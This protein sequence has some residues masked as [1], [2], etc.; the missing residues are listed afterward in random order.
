MTANEIREKF[1]N[2]FAGAN[3]RIVKSSSLLPKDDPTLLFTN[4]GMVQFKR[5]FLGEEKRDYARATTSQKCVRAGGKHNDLENVGHTAR[6]HT[7]FEML[8]NFSFG[9]Y[10]KREAI[11]FSW[12]LLTEGYGLPKDLLYV[13]VFRDDDEAYDIWKKDIGH[14]EQR[15]IRMGE[16]D[17]FWA[18]G[19][20]GPCGPCSEILIDQ[21]PDMGCDRPDCAP[22]CECD[23]YLELW[24]LVFMQYNRDESGTMTPLPKPSIDTG[25]GLERISAVLQGKKNNYDSDLFSGIFAEL[26]KISGKSYGADSKIDLSMR[27]IADHVRS[28]TFLIA[29]GIFPSNEGRGYVLRRILRRALRYGKAMGMDKPFLH[30]LSGSVVETMKSAY[31][32]LVGSHDFVSNLIFSE[33]ERFLQ[34]LENG[35][36]LLYDQVETLRGKGARTLPGELAFKLYDTYGFPLDILFDVGKEEGF[37]VDQAAFNQEME[38]QRAR[39]RKSWKGSGEAEIPEVY[40]ELLGRGVQTPFEGY[41]KR[42]VEATALALVKDGEEVKELRE[43]ETGEVVLDRTT[44]YGEAGGQV[45]DVGVIQ[46]SG[47]T[48]E[49]ENTVKYAGALVAHRGPIKSGTLKAGDRV[50][51]YYIEEARASTARNHTATHLLHAALRKILGTHVKQAGSLVSPDRL[52]FDFTHFAS[53]DEETL[54]KIEDEVNS[55]IW[56]NIEV[57]TRE[58]DM[59]EAMRTGAMALFEE[60]YGDRVR[61]VSIS[62]VSAEL[63]GGTHAG[64]TGDIGLFKIISESSVAAGIRRI[65]A[66]TG[67][68]AMAYLK[69]RDRQLKEISTLLKAGQEDLPARI[70]KL[71]SRQRS[72]E[73]EIEQLK[74]KETAKGVEQI[75]DKAREVKG[76]QL[77][78]TQVEAAG[79]KELRELGDRIRDKMKSGV[80]VLGS[81]ADGKAILLA[82]VTPDLTSRYQAG[83]IIGQVA[84]AVG[85]RGGGKPDIAQAGGPQKENLPKALEEVAELL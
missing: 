19:D 57:S 70:D 64:R 11:R 37:E 62:D 22:G 72:L 1:L 43:G 54:L 31:P 25:M 44:M 66:L 69:D 34:T 83:K 41:G 73:K 13:S 3:H 63:C 16:K 7:F 2:Y 38:K 51:V 28:V 29:D 71:L 36:S 23:R 5:V 39:S 75:L 67:P 9:D 65:E 78:A 24:N 32:D 82:L 60:R 61:L 14:P 55:A 59:E 80:I 74:S 85:G 4:A 56:H 27:V 15:I 12:E 47:A 30:D 8:G 6:H 53:I 21:G 77:L 48:M 68:G 49:V 10:F 84:K 33:E 17:N 50:D 45:G 81:E 42:L 40:R 76:V 20:T 46:S 35:L 79:P 52:R 26:E 18:M 58:M